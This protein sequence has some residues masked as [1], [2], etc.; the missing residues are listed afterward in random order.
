MMNPDIIDEI[1][2]GNIRPAEDPL[3]TT[4]SFQTAQKVA[5]AI[6]QRVEETLSVEQKL[7]WNAYLNARMELTDEYCRAFYRKGV[8]FGIRLMLEVL[9]DQA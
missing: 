2:S 9:R 6:E 7:H 5:F 4:D 8:I 3:P 1:F